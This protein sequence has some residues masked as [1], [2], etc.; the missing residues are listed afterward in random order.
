LSA[1]GIL[2]GSIP[3]GLADEFREAIEQLHKAGL[4]ATCRASLEADLN[5]DETYVDVPSE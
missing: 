4:M 1:G 5:D 2:L 3:R